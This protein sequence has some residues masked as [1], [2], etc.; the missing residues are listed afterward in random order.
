MWVWIAVVVIAV[1]VLVL[2][3]LRLLGRL[4][5]LN[6]AARRL[7]LRQEEALRVQSG[8]EK[9]QQTVLGLQQRAEQAQDHLEQIKA[10]RGK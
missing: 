3:G 7:Q 2:A 1:L 5:G 4:S 9:L 8:A 6:R 10:N